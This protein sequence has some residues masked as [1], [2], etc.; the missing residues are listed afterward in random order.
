MG[1]PQVICPGGTDYIVA[2]PFA[3]LKKAFKRRTTIMHNPEMTF[4]RPSDREMAMLGETMARKANRSRA[5]PRWSSPRRVFLP[6]SHGQAPLQP[7]GRPAFIR[8]LQG[9]IDPSIPVKVLPLHINDEAFAGAVV[10]E[11]EKL[12]KG[13]KANNGKF[14]R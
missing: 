10:D 12:V 1:I 5:T 8:G 3:G 11:F 9:V 14:D 6:E 2:G 7:N 4:V 13:E